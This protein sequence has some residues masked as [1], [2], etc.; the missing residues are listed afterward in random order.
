MR[1]LKTLGAHN[2]NRGRPAG[3]TGRGSLRGMLEAYE[4]RRSQGLLPATY[5]VLFG[6]LERA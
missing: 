2:V 3:L 4:A 5:E 1:E 6:T